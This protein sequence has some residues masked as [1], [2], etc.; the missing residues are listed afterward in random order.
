MTHILACTDGSVYAPSIYDH[1]AWA[2]RRSG[3]SVHVL[4]L[5]DAHHE[6]AGSTNLSGNIGMD[7]GD[8]L[9]AEMVRF[10]ET[11][12]RLA[13]ERG[14]AIL[15]QAHSHLADAGVTDVTTD[16]L[17]GELVETVSDL[18]KSADLVVIGKRGESA[19][20]AK[21]HLGSNLERVIRASVRPVLV[22]AR[23]FS[24]IHSF[25]LAYDGS[26]STD[27]AVRFAI[28]NPLLRG[29]KCHLLRAGRI[30]ADAEWFLRETEARLRAADYDVQSHALPGEPEAIISAAVN[31][32]PAQLLVMGAYGHSR[33]RQL[34]I[35][36]TTTTMIRSCHVSVLMFR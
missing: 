35:G 19:D 4:H 8:N 23:K 15:A 3:A 11:Q 25:V 29:L 27:K 26:P 28:E 16:Q 18:E 9:L 13:R 17:H 1:S 36:S 10:E 22:A 33:I 24:A 30:D 12:N 34:I 32:L 14:T 7:E 2:A 31:N 6:R 20:F 5:L 21:L